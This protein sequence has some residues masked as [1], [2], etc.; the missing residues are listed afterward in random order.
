VLPKYITH[1]AQEV[2]ELMEFVFMLSISL[3]KEI[4]TPALGIYAR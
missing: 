2:V 1:Q 4:Q 3:K